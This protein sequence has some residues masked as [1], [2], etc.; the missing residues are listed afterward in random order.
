MIEIIKKK[1]EVSS[2]KNYILRIVVA[3]FLGAIIIFFVQTCVSKVAMASDFYQNGKTLV[4]KLKENGFSEDEILKIF[5]DARVQFHPEILRKKASG[6]SYF[7]PRFGLLA[8]ESIERGKKV[9]A[10]RSEVFKAVDQRFGVEKE[11]LAGIFR[12]ETNLGDIE[13]KYRV[14]NGLYTLCAIK[15]PRS[16]FFGRELVNFLV[17]CKINQL[18][19]L[20]IM[21]SWAGA[22]GLFQF[23]P[24][25]FLSFAI[26]GNADGRID[27]FNFDD[28]VFSAANY[29]VKNGWKKGDSAKVKKAIFAY[30]RCDNYVKAVLAYANALK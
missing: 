6:I 10:V 15:N 22:F 21:G 2:L 24:S 1:K 8:K 28:A 23:M 29:L 9:L 18:D 3:F 5:S 19:P 11:I 26:D 27:L 14:F 17:I 4:E 30:N 16:D 25:S 13:Y 12:I 20:A 7:D